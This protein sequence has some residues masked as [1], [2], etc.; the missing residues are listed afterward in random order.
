MNHTKKDYD[1][2]ELKEL[3]LGLK[4]ELESLHGITKSIKQK[5]NEK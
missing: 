5:K 3:L 2:T 1:K 4:A